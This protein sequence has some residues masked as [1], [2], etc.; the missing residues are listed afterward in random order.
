MSPDE[1]TKYL[2]LDLKVGGEC[3]TNMCS[4]TVTR[5]AFQGFTGLSA[6]VYDFLVEDR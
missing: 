1:Q 3:T 5:V 6:K 2:D 4:K